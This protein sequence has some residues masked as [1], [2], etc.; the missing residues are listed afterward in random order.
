LPSPGG[1]VVDGL[2]NV[3][4]TGQARSRT[5]ERRLVAER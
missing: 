2:I 3:R 4:G 1:V 5:G